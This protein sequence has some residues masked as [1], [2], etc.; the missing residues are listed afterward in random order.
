MS[1]N[2]CFSLSY[3]KKTFFL[4]I[5]LLFSFQVSATS[6]VNQ[7]GKSLY[8]DGGGCTFNINGAHYDTHAQCDAGYGLGYR[9]F[10]ILWDDGMNQTWCIRC[11]GN[12]MH[13]TFPNQPVVHYPA[14]AICAECAAGY[15]RSN[16]QCVLTC[17]PDTLKIGDECVTC[18]ANCTV[19]TNATT[20]T[21]CNAGF[22]LYNGQCVAACPAGTY[23]S[24]NT[25][26]ECPRGSVLDNGVCA[27][28]PLTYLDSTV[29]VC[30]P[31]NATCSGVNPTCGPY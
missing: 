14:D 22:Y 29:N 11:P 28:P 19:C 5:F 1:K 23:V 18:P 30:C 8:V 12:C 15:V 6:I 9:F 7:G 26:A 4:F 24:G 10:N 13:Y 20:C 25:C 21:T 3:L 16:G 27:C 31:N 2:S 17:P